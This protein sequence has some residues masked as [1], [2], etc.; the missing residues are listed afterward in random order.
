MSALRTNLYI[1][2]FNFYYGC[3]KSTSYKWVDFRAL[4]TYLLDPAKNTVEQIKY[5]TAR[6]DGRGDPQRPTRQDAYLRAIQAADARLTIVYGHFLTNETTLP[7]ADGRGLVRVLRTEEKGSDVNLA[8]H[9][10]RDAFTGK[11][12]CA[13]LVT[14]DSDL[15]EPLRIVRH[16]LGLPVGIIFPVAQKGRRPSAELSKEASFIR[17]VRA[18]ALKH[19]Q[20]P[21]PVRSPAG[22]ISKPTAW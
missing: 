15:V 3:V 16:E 18:G 19:S 13:V 14:N 11:M 20:L 4:C 1:D 9:L 22:D 8:T 12:D 5:F 10:L 2:G 21:D 17:R 7:R 6:V